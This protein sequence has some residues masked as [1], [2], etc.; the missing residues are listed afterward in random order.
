[1]RARCRPWCTGDMGRVRLVELLL[2]EQQPRLAP[3]AGRAQRAAARLRALAQHPIRRA[4]RLGDGLVG[5]ALLPVELLLHRDGDGE[6]DAD[7]LLAAHLAERR[8]MQVSLRCRGPRA[9]WPFAARPGQASCWFVAC[10]TRRSSGM[11]SRNTLG[12]KRFVSTTTTSLC[13][14]RSPPP[15]SG[16]GTTPTVGAAAG[17]AVARV[18]TGV[19]A[20][21]AA[22][23]GIAPAAAAAAAACVSDG[24]VHV[25]S[26]VKVLQ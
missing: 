3:L 17:T 13:I 2:L 8:R 22:S 23:A 20:A 26:P 5:V 10:W 11:P 7:Q 25:L 24:R 9:C 19:A 18:A 16:A 6:G 15:A 14:R 4:R 1:M 21:G 12:R